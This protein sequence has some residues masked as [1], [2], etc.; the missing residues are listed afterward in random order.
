MYIVAVIIL[1]LFME[2]RKAIL[3]LLLFLCFSCSA[4]KMLE[5]KDYKDFHIDNL[6]FTNTRLNL[7]LEYFNPN[8]F[9]L[10][11]RRS[12]VDIYINNNYL[13][14]SASDTLINILP[15][16]TFVLPIKF[17]VDMKNV[18]KNAWNT[19]VGSEVTV[20]V[21]GNLKVGKA[22]VFMSVPVNYEGKHKFAFF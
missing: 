2:F 3:P 17:D 11:L 15:R 4:P 14:H 6:G 13:G 10:Q 8:N 21:N 5:Y 1:F 22:N 16:K 9:G 12:D 19:L 7:G 18:F 20:K